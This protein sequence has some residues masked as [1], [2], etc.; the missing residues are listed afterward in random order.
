MISDKIEKR[1]LT[2]ILCKVLYEKHQTKMILRKLSE[3]FIR[4]RLGSKVIWQASASRSISSSIE[5]QN[6][7]HP[8]DEAGRDSQK[9]ASQSSNSRRE[10][11]GTDESTSVS[12]DVPPRSQAA[13]HGSLSQVPMVVKLLG[14]GGAIPFWALSPTVAP[15]LPLHMFGE[16]VISNAGTLQIAYGATILSFLGGVHWG[17]AMTSLT[18]P[19]LVGQRY[20]W[21][22]VPCLLAWPTVCFS[23]PEAAGMQAGLLGLVYV[24]DRDWAKKGLLPPWFM[25]L[26]ARLTALASSGCMLTVLGAML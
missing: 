1:D 11:N 25:T 22:V 12:S 26:R 16:T 10:T 7:S 15:Y 19:Q 23:I 3:S 17:L 13:S 8:E 21:S 24:V 2:I 6:Q 14:F 5:N 20:V 4:P 9:E 18:P